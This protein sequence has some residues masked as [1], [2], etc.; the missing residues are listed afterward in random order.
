MDDSNN[1]LSSNQS[2]SIQEFDSNMFIPLPDEKVW[3]IKASDQVTGPYSQ[4]EIT[5]LLLEYK[6]TILDE[7]ARPFSRWEF[8]RHNKS[9][10]DQLELLIRVTQQAKAQDTV[11]SI[12]KT[13]K[14]NK[15]ITFDKFFIENLNF[16]LLSRKKKRLSLILIGIL[17]FS[18]SFLIYLYFFKIDK[19]HLMELNQMALE[20]Q[21]LYELS[22][23]KKS[24]QQYKMIT[25]KSDLT[26]SADIQ[27]QILAICYDKK[28]EVSRNKLYH[29]FKKN[30]VPSSLINS[31]YNAIGLSYLK[32]GDFEMA[33]KSYERSLEY[34]PNNDIALLNMALLEYRL[35]HY[36]ESLAFLK[37]SNSTLY[38]TERD[39][40]ET[41]I[42]SEANLT[43]RPTPSLTQLTNKNDYLKTQIILENINIANRLKM[44]I[45]FAPYLESLTDLLIYSLDDFAIEPSIDPIFFEVD[46]QESRCH[47][48]ENI[49][50]N[51]ENRTMKISTI[52]MNLLS[53]ICLAPSQN[54]SEIDENINKI[55]IKSPKNQIAILIKTLALFK[56]KKFNEVNQMLA[57]IE[58]TD[59]A[60]E[61]YLHGHYCNI[62]NDTDCAIS[63]F[64][65]ILQKNA[66]LV[67]VISDLFSIAQSEKKL[68]TEKLESYLKNG[69][70][71]SPQF[72]PLL[73]I[74]N[75]M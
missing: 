70:K 14:T 45:V 12:T 7:V 60:L 41:I 47:L 25:G 54:W 10:M 18:T 40:F 62:N 9:L 21:K 67:G 8:I 30:Q 53:V 15:S 37:K 19:V 13:K 38:A 22:D 51:P 23:Y 66:N 29:Y 71:H 69:L 72:I 55:L 27:Y 74:K 73:K 32:D 35:S 61:K 42:R 36:K 46:F 75:N 26:A 52:E 33:R 49:A 44:N 16:K 57:S 39:Y 1:E 6:I 64:E 28:T 3:L 34:F 11:A 24:Y 48:I 20:A 63:Y 4:N 68:S 17:F 2:N 50:M 58:G 5:Q 59:L 56:L 43:L 65:K 31:A